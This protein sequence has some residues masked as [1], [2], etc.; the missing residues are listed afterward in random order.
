[1]LWWWNWTNVVQDCKQQ[2]PSFSNNLKY[3]N[4]VV[5]HYLPAFSKYKNKTLLIIGGGGSTN[6]LDWQSLN[7]YDYVWSV[8]HFFLH[9]ILKDVKVDLV[10]MMA[11]P[12]L[13]GKEWLE[14][15]ERFK[16]YV[17]FEV[18]DKW[19]GYKFDDYDRYFCMHTRFYSKL[20]ACVRMMIF[21]AEL[22]ITSI[23]FVGLDGES[24]ILEGDHAFQPGKT[25][26][27]T[28]KG[29]FIEQYYSFWN[30]IQT[31]YPDVRF[32]NLGGG[33]EY[34]KAIM[35]SHSG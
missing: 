19:N 1:M 16:P 17:G 20:G 2:F 9:P 18:N 33:E 27:P 25:T 6:N 35:H 11:E 15:R 23:D 13:N 24:A 5:Y 10:M 7:T 26:M 3:N 14:Y 34:H 12:D 30:Y 8:N 31:S 22:G 32:Y 29:S 4:S 21:A 28:T